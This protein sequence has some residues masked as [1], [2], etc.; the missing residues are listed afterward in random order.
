MKSEIR[1][2]A[3]PAGGPKSEKKWIVAERTDPDLI[4][5]LLKLRG[6]EDQ[7]I[8]LNPDFV[9]QQ[10]DPFLM[11]GM[12]QA[13]DRLIEAAHK[14]EVIGIFADY[15]TDGTPGAALLL[16]GLRQLGLQT[17][18]YIPT[19]SE[20]YG[21]SEQGLV[22]LKAANAGV[23]IT[24]DLGITANHEAE[25]AVTLGLD[26][27]ITDHHLVQPERY[28][29]RAYAVINPKQADCPYPF[30]DLCGGG[31]AWKLLSA[32]LTQI[33]EFDPTLLQ[34]RNP[35][36]IRR[37]A[38]DLAAISTVC[39]MMPLVGEN[40]LLAH[41]GLQVLRQTRRPGLKALF[42]LARVDPERIGAGTIGFQIGPRINAPTRLAAEAYSSETV[43]GPQASLALG[44][45][46]TS[47]VTEADFLADQLEQYNLSRQEQ[48]EAVYQQAEA[49]VVAEGL[50]NRKLI[51]LA[52][53]D[54]PTGLV[55]L[56][57]GRLMQKFGRPTIVLSLQGEEAVGSARSIDGFHLLEA[58]SHVGQNLKRFGGHARAAGLTIERQH[59]ELIYDQLQSLADDRLSDEQLGPRLLIEAE[60][61][62]PDVTSA[63]AALLSHLGPHGIGNPRPLFLLTA[64]RVLEV[65]VLGTLGQHRKLRLQ[66]F[67][68][69][70]PIS[71]IAFSWQ[72]EADVF[73]VGQTV[74][75]A[76][77]LD[78]HTWN[79]H[80]STQLEVVDARLHG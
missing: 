9:S 73:K 28:P 3:S 29:K 44:L 43:P 22:A 76:C 15:D 23:V 78:E 75:L 7:E 68:A 20:G 40:R 56:V 62:A 50:M 70:A 58:L 64:V 38:L 48:L 27:I 36:S 24:I 19:R 60:I 66:I 45:L 79:G 25:M 4:K 30:K 61:E 72:G 2:P 51:M 13:V 54:W 77:Y 55:G 31:I 59:L 16:D 52:G 26:L 74:D 67:G 46:V 49:R 17:A 12:R 47:S 1:N 42:R 80:T 39:D 69:K 65:R 18:V 34:G 71:G 21:L 10:H 6:V 33:E 37:W 53:A 57:A 11:K 41:Y 63:T 5:H 32:F 14:Q 8:F 35:E